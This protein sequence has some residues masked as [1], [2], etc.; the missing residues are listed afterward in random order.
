MGGRRGTKQ[1][2]ERTIA[3]TILTVGTVAALASMLGDV[4][5]LRAGVVVA[6]LMAFAAVFV[7]WRQLTTERA[8]HAEEMKHEMDLRAKQATRHH[9]ESVAMIERYNARAENLRAVIAKLRS[10]LAAARS[11]L[12]T[13]RGNAA[14]LRGEVAERQARI[15]ALEKQIA[16]LE[17]E[18]TANIVAMPRQELSPSIQD[19]WGADEHPTMVNLAKLKL[20]LLEDEDI[21][22][23]QVS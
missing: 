8:W 14:W 3:L 12:S 6:I 16:E 7:V 9:N 17:A 22:Q 20:D 21:V 1:S 19:I 23:H 11:E 10:Q 5:A 2:H 4:W 18:D 13:M 15:E